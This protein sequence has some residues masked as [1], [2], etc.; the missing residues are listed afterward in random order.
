MGTRNGLP[1]RAQ[2]T[3]RCLWLPGRKPERVSP[4]RVAPSLSPRRPDLTPPC[5]APPAPSC[6]LECNPQGLR[7]DGGDGCCRSSGPGAAPPAT[8]PQ[9]W[10]WKPGFVLSSSPLGEAL[11]GNPPGSAQVCPNQLD[12]PLAQRPRPFQGAE[13]RAQAPLTH[14]V[15]AP[16]EPPWP[17][18]SIPSLPLPSPTS[19]APGPAS[20]VQQGK[21]LSTD[22]LQVKKP[23][24][25]PRLARTPCPGNRM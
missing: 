24:P 2:L 4:K 11:R 21:T 17:A 5:P 6:A 23:P 13:G 16:Q 22:G 25:R 8:R 9:G 3:A 14:T 7:A 15:H 1:Q 10:S 20:P 18:G 19:S 12:V